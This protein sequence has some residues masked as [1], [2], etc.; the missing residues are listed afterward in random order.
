ME[1]LSGDFE[2][3]RYKDECREALMQVIDSKIAGEPV[4]TPAPASV[5][6]ARQSRAR[7][8]AASGTKA[9]SS[10]STSRAKSTAPMRRR[11]TV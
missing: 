8:S 3:T 4:E 5:S 7:K 10:D 2:A 11:K 9:K 6:K 1:T